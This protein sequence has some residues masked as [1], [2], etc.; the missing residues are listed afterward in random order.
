[1]LGVPK[2]HDSIGTPATQAVGRLTDARTVQIIKDV[3]RECR[4]RRELLIQKVAV[5]VSRLIQT[6]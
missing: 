1:M 4:K 6:V 5:C 3:G 2:T